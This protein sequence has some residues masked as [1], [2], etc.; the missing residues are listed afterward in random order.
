M[1][2]RTGSQVPT[3]ERVG[4]WDH[5]DGPEAVATLSAYGFS[6]DGAQRHEMDVYLARRADGTPSATSVGLSVPRQNGKSYAARWYA[7]WQAAVCGRLVTY[8]AHNGDTVHEFFDMLCDTFT[9]QEAYPDFATLLDG[10][11]YRQPGK[12]RISFVGGG[13]IKFATRTN[14]GSRG[15]TCD[16]IVIDE[17]Q[18]LTEAQLNAMLPIMSAGPHGAPQVIY[19]GTPPDSSCPG[20]VFRRMRDSAHAEEWDGAAWWMEWAAGS[21]P[22][23]DATPAQLL[24]LAYETNPALGVRITEDAVRNEIA[25][26]GREGFARERLGWWR[27]RASSVPPLLDPEDWGACEVPDAEANAVE[28]K[29]ALGVKFSPDG[30]TYAMSAAVLPDKGTP[31]VELVEVGNAGAGIDALAA[32]IGER[33]ES[34]AL[35][36]IDGR[37][38]ASALAQSL[39]ERG[40]PP[41]GIHECTTADM[42]AATSMLSLSVRGRD[43]RHIASPAMDESATRSIPRS[44]GR[45]GATG[46]G[47]GPDSISA[48]VESGALAL[49]AVRTTRR[50]PRRRQVVSW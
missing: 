2:S 39:R 33:S 38:A 4:E 37:S 23:E 27:P 30:L 50:D 31:L 36:A 10:R 46:F 48:P 11:P 7:V 42:V 5:T 16:L 28:G 45:N 24:D 14:S 49:W 25:T 20:T 21:L 43:I 1:A 41:R 3:F 34:L 18:E 17:A 26:M 40:Y 13:R 35:V 6:F 29:T 15:G 44:L 32:W 19:I 8:S 12:E 9:D 47:D 22:P